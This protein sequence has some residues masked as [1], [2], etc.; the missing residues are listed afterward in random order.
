MA[1]TPTQITFP[2]ALGDTHEETGVSGY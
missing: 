2:Q 1:L